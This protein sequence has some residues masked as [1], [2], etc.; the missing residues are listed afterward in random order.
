MEHIRD[1]E[2]SLVLMMVPK[3]WNGYQMRKGPGAAFLDL[4]ISMGMKRAAGSVEMK[5]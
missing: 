4:R 1:V 5:V 2:M 3:A